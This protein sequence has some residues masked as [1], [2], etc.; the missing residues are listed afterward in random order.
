MSKEH[1]KTFLF[2]DQGIDVLKWLRSV[3]R[4]NTDAEVARYAFGSLATLMLAWKNG[5]EI[6]LRSPDGAERK[7]HPVFKLDEPKEEAD[8]VEKI[9]NFTAGMGAQ[10]PA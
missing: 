7:Y 10:I 6:I 4:L 8:P 9:K 3:C 2:D 1:R 5:D